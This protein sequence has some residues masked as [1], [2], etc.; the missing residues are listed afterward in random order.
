MNP[1]AEMPLTHSESSGFRQDSAQ[2][3]FARL[4]ALY[5]D[6]RCNGMD[7]L[8]S[9][10]TADDWLNHPEAD[11][12]MAVALVIRPPEAV[13]GRI[14]HTLD[15]LAKDFPELYCYPADDL[16]ITV[17]DILR[18][19][20][21]LE[22]P[23]HTLLSQYKTCMESAVLPLEPFSI[24]CRGLTFSGGALM[25]QGFDD[26]GLEAL[27]ASLRPALRAAGLPLEE[28]YETTSCHITAVRF[29]EKLRKPAGLLARLEQYADTDFGTFEVADAE[30][31]YH[32]WYD[33]KKEG[34]FTLS[35]K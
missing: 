4:T 23:S 3:R 13:R 33:S 9:G 29:P 24:R 22:K 26:G 31:T 34:L 17:L 21:G 11:T 28:R 20:P 19:R 32:N 18:G 25:V 12:R 2:E 8:L 27:R 35:W 14:R 15:E 10:G 30:L 6:I 5:S 1:A 16:H 7:T